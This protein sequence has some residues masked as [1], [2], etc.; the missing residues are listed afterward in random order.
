M[1]VTIRQ[2]NSAL[3]ALKLAKKQFSNQRVIAELIQAML[4]SKKQSV[5]LQEDE[6]KFVVQ[7]SGLHEQFAN[8]QKR[9]GG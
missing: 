9:S 2:L 7:L 4:R 8:V 3:S 1:R 5:E 6:G